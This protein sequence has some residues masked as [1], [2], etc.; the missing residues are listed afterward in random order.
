MVMYARKQQRLSDGC[1]DRR[2]DAQPYQGGDVLQALKYSSKSHPSSGDH[3]HE[4][5]RD[6][7][8]PS[9]PNKMLRR[10]DSPENKY[11]DSTGHS[12]AKNV[13]IHRVRERDGGTSYSPQEN[14]H[15]HSAL[16]SSNSHSSNPSNNPS[17][18]S[19]AP[20][21]SAD[22]WSEHI[23]SSGKKYYYN[24][25]T[26]VSQWEKPKEW[27]ERE[28]RQ[29]EANKMAVNSFPKDRDYRREVM[30]A[31]ATSGFASGMEDK[32]S[33]D[34]S[35]LLPQNILSQTSRHNDRDYRLPRAETHSSSAP[36]QHPIKPVVHPTAAPSTVPSSPFTL[37][38]D[39]QPKKSFDAN[40]A[41]TLSKLPTPTSSVPAQR[42]ERKESTSG[43]KS[44]SHPCTTPSTSSASGLNPTSA[45]PASASAIPVSPVP[46]SPIPPLLQD[47]NL[48][49]QLLPALQAT[50]QL[51][52]SN[53]D[54]S[55]INEVLTAAVTQ[56]SLQSIIHKFLT[57]GPSAFN[58][59]SLISQAA[60]LSTQAQP[61]NQSPMSLTSD[62]SSPRSYVSPR[63]STPQTNTVPI[64]PLISTPP[65]SSQPKVSTPVVKQGPVSQS[66]TQQPVTA[67][68]QQ[69]HEPVSPRSLQRSN[70]RSP[71]PGPNHTSSSN[72][73][74]TAVVPQ[75]SS[76]RPPCS[77][78]PT[79][80]A[81]FNENL[82]KHVQ[83]W[84]A[85]HAEKQ[86]SRLREEAH[87]MG[88]VHMS[89]IC[90]ELKNLRSLVRVCEIQAT[91]REQRI[92]FLRQQIKELEK[93]K[94]QNSFMV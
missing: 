92:L 11:S 55:K 3:R 67:D 62:A 17:K 90:T 34:A 30:Q 48:L 79:L 12:K 29:K 77:L 74:N 25:R 56:A 42:T 58:I 18:T 60:Q 31:T 50:L 49:R 8:D 20:Y 1:H 86:A 41:S 93:L 27:L 57:A 22:D 7:A 14:S 65:V 83:G 6:A 39:H 45:P 21:D 91:L 40:G 15:N 87:N 32:H 4:K 23:S 47:P 38:S 24:C 9:P 54:I 81:H 63:I 69:G 52:N 53:V 78:T 80:A 33:S 5:M 85:D 44:V 66:A 75:N 36:V 2:G 89:E 59:T 61:S 68:K 43:D 72:A 28:Q 51:N 88:S 10:S 37:Q 71:S 70:Q 35:S 13:H 19:D 64:K 76:A 73:S 82:I 26:E 84:P 16:H 94:N 46:Q